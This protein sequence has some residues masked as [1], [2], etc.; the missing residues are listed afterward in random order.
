MKSQVVI[1]ITGVS[2]GIGKTCFDYLFAKGYKVYGTSRFA[3]PDNAFLL[4]MDVTKPNSIRSA[5]NYVLQKEGKIDVLINNAGISVVG[6]AEMTLTEDARQQIETNF[7]GVVNTT[8][9]VL[10]TMRQQHAGKIINISSLAG[11]FAIPYQSYYTASKFALEGYSESLRMELKKRNIQVSLIEPGDFKTEISQNRI[12]SNTEE[13]DDY[14]LGLHSAMEIIVKGERQ[15]DDTKKIA[16]V[17]AH[18]I[19]SRNPRLRYL[20]GKPMDLL[21]AK[22][23]RILPPRLFEW[24]IMNHYK[25]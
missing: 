2:S 8:N 14:S 1:L 4:K 9:A 20:V 21:A 19:R 10:P 23:K 13:N 5:V 18:I 25:L 24:I 15:G 16:R 17:V 7:W 12:L 6:S 22:L 11:L 3:E